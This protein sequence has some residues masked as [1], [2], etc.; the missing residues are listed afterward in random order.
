MTLFQRLNNLWKLSAYEPMEIN[1]KSQIGDII[2]PLI[3]L[4]EPKL[5]EIIRKKVDPLDLINK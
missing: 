3:K 2:V 5:A 1:R 4:S